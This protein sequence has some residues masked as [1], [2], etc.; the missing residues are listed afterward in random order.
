M[1]FFNLMISLEIGSAIS[2]YTFL[3]AWE[4]NEPITFLHLQDTFSPYS[5]HTMG[6]HRTV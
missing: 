4:N 1:I 2:S 5:K 3:H 6:I